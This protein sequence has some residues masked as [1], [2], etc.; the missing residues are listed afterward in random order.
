MRPRSIS[1]LSLALLGFVGLTGALAAADQPIDFH[2]QGARIY[3]SSAQ[4]ALTLPSQASPAAVAQGFL[5]ERLASRTVDSL[6]VDRQ[7]EW[8][9][10]THVRLRQQIGDLPVYGTYVRAA[11]N[12][13]GELVHLI[14]NLATPPA[15]G[16][17]P[18]RVSPEDALAAAV[19]TNHPDFRGSESFF[20]TAPTVERVAIPM[21]SGAMQEGFLVETWENASNLLYHTL[22]GAGGQVL[23]VQLR[24]N[25]DSYNIFPDHPGNSN[26]TIVA[27][28]GAGNAESP[29]GWIFGGTQ[30]SI[31]IAGNNVNAYL[32]TDT[33]NSPDPG[34]T[35]INDGNFVTAANLGQ[36]PSVFSNQEVA[37][38]SLFYLNNAIHDKL[39]RHGFV[40]SAGNFQENN[41]GNGGSGSDSVAAEAQDGSGLNN[42][43]FS[44]PSDGSNPRMQMFLWDR[45]NPRRDGDVDSDIPWH[46]YGHGLTWRMIGNM[47]G[48]MSGAIGEGNSDVL[49][50]LTNDDDVVG[51]YSFNNPLGI[52]SEPYDGYSRTY[53]DFDGGSVHFDGEIYAATMWDLK[54]RY[55][56]AGLSVDTLWDDMVG[57]MNFTPA[58]PAME[59]MRDGILA[60]AAGSGRECL[61]WESFAAFGIGDGAQATVKGGGPF[62][63]G[64]VT[65]TESFALPAECG[66]GGPGGCTDTGGSCRN[67]G[68]CCSGNCSG[69]RP[70]DRVCL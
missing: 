15:R 8:N 36:D 33:S 47:S 70:A 54:K 59:D 57:G 62:G 26:Q 24:T 5:A 61:I 68:D 42:A 44:T 10:V 27:G 14:E 16:L 40:E 46:E 55:Q 20:W 7:F 18:A 66:G 4:V 22:V 37:V 28:P 63:G 11:V 30:L 45:S 69:G 12:R 3:G 32:D 56:A 51:E 52:R 2:A 29:S 35:A 9:G 38:Q 43:N 21:A 13:Y 19:K 41:F 39:Y 49:S 34:G 50:I 1:I 53:G 60:Q 6:V 17:V 23:G 58:G 65:V 25:T 48:P 31:H 67:D 64:S